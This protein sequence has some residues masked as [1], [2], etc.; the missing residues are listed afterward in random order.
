MEACWF[1]GMIMVIPNLVVGTD[2]CGRKLQCGDICKFQIKLQRPRC[3]EKV[4]EMM[5]MIVYDADSYAYAFETLDDYAPILCMYCAE[6]GS[7]KKVW[8]SSAENFKNI[9]NGDSWKDMYYRNVTKSII[10]DEVNQCIDECISAFADWYGY[11]YQNQG[12]YK[13]LKQMKPES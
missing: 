6:Q 8:E 11:G 5:G 7:V 10:N 12:Y 4:E 13:L 3:E 1:G 2:R 9:P